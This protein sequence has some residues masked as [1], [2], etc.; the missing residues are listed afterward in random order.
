MSYMTISSQEKHHC[1]LG[2]C[3][4]AHPT[5]LLLKILG[6][7]MHGPSPPPQIFWGTVPP[8]P[9]LGLRPCLIESPDTYS[10]PSWRVHGWKNELAD[11][12]SVNSGQK[13]SVP[14]R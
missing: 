5:T 11:E 7:P 4:H 3:F 12:F 10:T 13:F 8:S 9:L 2:S 6:G 14:Q 1:S